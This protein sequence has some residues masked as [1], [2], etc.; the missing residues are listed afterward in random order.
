MVEHMA[1]RLH[2]MAEPWLNPTS[3]L[4]RG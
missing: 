2:H 4:S 3:R 1:I